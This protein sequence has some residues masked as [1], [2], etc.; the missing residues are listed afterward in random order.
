MAVKDIAECAA[1]DDL[2]RDFVGCEVRVIARNKS[3]ARGRLA[4]CA[5]DGSITVVCADNTAVRLEKAEV[6]AIS[7]APQRDTLK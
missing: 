3:V 5:A 2:L 1:E 6:A 4:G 7:L